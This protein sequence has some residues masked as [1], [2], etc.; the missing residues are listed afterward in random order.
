MQRLHRGDPPKC[1]ANFQHGRDDWSVLGFT[2]KEEIRNALKSMQGERCAYCECQLSSGNQHIEHFRQ[3]SCYPQGTFAWDNLFW[4]CCQNDSCGKHKDSLPRT[5]DHRDLIKADV[6]N[7]ERFFHFMSDG[8]ISIRSGLSSAD[9]RRAEETLRIFNLDPH[10]GRLRAMRRTAAAGYK[11]TGLAVAQL[12][13][14]GAAP[15]EC[16]DFILEELST[17]SGLPFCTAIRHT[18]LPSSMHLSTP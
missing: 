11:D 2:E 1:L 3:R 9:R 12:M 8:T 6:D 14:E 4:S 16:L 10:H 15:S 7:P 5:Y 17:T 18:L 13:D